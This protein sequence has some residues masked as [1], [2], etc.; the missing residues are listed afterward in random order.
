MKFRRTA[1]NVYVVSWIFRFLMDLLNCYHWRHWSSSNFASFHYIFLWWSFGLFC[2][3]ENLSFIKYWTVSFVFFP[4]LS[5]NF[6]K[7]FLFFKRRWFIKYGIIFKLCK[8]YI[9]NSR[10]IIIFIVW[11]SSLSL[12]F[13]KVENTLLMLF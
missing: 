1:C 3:F 9:E 11:N 13:I 5:K 12:G 6:D 7:S 4:F 8:F 2:I 10:I